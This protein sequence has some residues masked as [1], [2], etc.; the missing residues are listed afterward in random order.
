MGR[1]CVLASLMIIFFSFYEKRALLGKGR[2]GGFPPPGGAPGAPGTP[3]DLLRNIFFGVILTDG[4]GGGFWPFPGYCHRIGLYHRENHYKISF[5]PVPSRDPSP[6]GGL[7]GAPGAPRPGTP[8]T[9]FFGPFWPFCQNPV[10]DVFI[11]NP[12]FL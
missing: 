4:A 8:K 1:L 11:S 9:P 12:Q 10:F 3:G 7:P 2:F 6:P 5:Y